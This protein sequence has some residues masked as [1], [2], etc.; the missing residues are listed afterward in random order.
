[1]IHLNDLGPPRLLQLQPGN[2]VFAHIADTHP[3]VSL[4]SVTIAPHRCMQPS[5][6]RGDLSAQPH[7]DTRNE[8]HRHQRQHS[9]RYTVFHLPDLTCNSATLLRTTSTSPL[10][11]HL[12]N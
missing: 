7:P 4:R 5:R 11:V 1:M 6:R 3:K 2:P 10:P 12:L 8:T 9:K